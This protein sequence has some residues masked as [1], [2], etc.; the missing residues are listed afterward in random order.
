[1]LEIIGARDLLFLL[2]LNI[3]HYKENQLPHFILFFF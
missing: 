2:Q 3:S 1:M